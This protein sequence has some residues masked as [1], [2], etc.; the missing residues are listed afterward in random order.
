MSCRW[1]HNPESIRPALQMVFRQDRCIGCGECMPV[2]PEQA[3][4]L[5]HDCIM[6][7]PEK[8]VHCCQCA[9][10]CPA[11]ARESAGKRFTTDEILHIIEKDRLFY[12]Q[13]NGGVTFSGGE[14]LFQH[15]FLIDILKHCK[16]RDI[17]RTVD[18]SGFT[19]YKILAE[20][21]A[22]TDIFLFDIKHMD[23]EKHRAHTGVFNHR[24]L[25]NLVNLSKIGA[26]TGTKIIVRFPLIP[27]FNDDPDHVNRLG[28]FISQLP[29]I[30]KIDILPF[31]AS[32]KG[33]YKTFD[34]PYYMKK[35]KPP[36]DAQIRAAAGIL[37]QYDIEINI[38]G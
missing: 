22:Y 25:E 16:D 17:H 34:L 15:G 7:D 1:C 26:K 28:R 9:D 14:P 8:C 2:C 30:P 4:F 3:I 18:T 31:H 21:T 38:D 19:D 11:G 37:K 27:G 24:I 33:K 32:A 5:S 10:I 36:D 12:E 13:S 35:I 6:T 23:T 29:G 20:T